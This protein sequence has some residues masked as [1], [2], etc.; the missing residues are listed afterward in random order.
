MSHSFNKLGSKNFLTN[1][2]INVSQNLKTDFNFFVEIVI[3]SPELDNDRDLFQAF[4]HGKDVNCD[5]IW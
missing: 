2:F 4:F 1:K 5:M 3:F